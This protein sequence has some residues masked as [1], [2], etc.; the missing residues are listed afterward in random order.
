MRGN[1]SYYGGSGGRTRRGW[2]R[3]RW[4]DGITDSMDMSLSDLQELVMD[5]EAWHAVIHG[6]AKS[7]TWLK[8]L[9]SSSSIEIIMWFLSFNLLIWYIT[10]IDLCVLKNP[11][12]PEINS[13]WSWCMSFL[14]CC[15]ILFAKNFVEDFCIYVHQWYWPIVLFFCVLFL[16]G[17]GIRVMV[18]S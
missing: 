15:W 1:R 14:M 13:T 18:A 12:I 2:Q 4:L 17:F 11:C 10:F 8:W 5:R 16:S 7:Q 9:S 3:M 6:V